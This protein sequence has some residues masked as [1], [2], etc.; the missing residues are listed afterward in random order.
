MVDCQPLTAFLALPQSRSLLNQHSLSFDQ[1]GKIA[2]DA[3]NALEKKLGRSIV[4]DKNYLKEK[5]N[6]KLK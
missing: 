2:G 6:L 3:R 1:I 5:E 4:S